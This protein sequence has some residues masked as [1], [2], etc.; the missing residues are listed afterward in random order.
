MGAVVV[1]L[2]S[3]K[4]RLRAGTHHAGNLEHWEYDTFRLRWDN[5]WEGTDL[6]TFT[7][8]AGG[9]PSRLDLSGVSLQRAN[10][11]DRQ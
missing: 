11:A 2:E 5:A 4:L 6:V 7:I 9:I 10:R 3:G 8:G 1:A